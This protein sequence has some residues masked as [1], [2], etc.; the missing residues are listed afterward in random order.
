MDF[1]VLCLG[2]LCVFFASY[3]YTPIPSNIE[4]QWKVR[5]LDAAAKIST[6]VA[7]CFE[8][9]GIM[10][11]DEFISMILKLDYTEPFSDENITVTDMTF[12][13]IPVRLYLPKRKSEIPRRAVIYIHGGAYCLGSFKQRA[14]DFLNRW[15]A[16][17]LDAVV[18]G[19]DYRLAPQHLFPTQFEDCITLVKFFLQDEILAKYGVDPTRICVSGDSSGGMLAAAVTQEVQ[20]NLEIKHKI[21][22]QALL[23]P[24]LQIIDSCLPSY[25]ENKHGLVLTRDIGIKLVS[26][27]LT[28]DESLPEAMRRNQYMPMES[29]PLF[30]F[31]N[32]S[33]LLPKK[34]RKDYVYVEPILGRYNYSLP[35]LT[36]IR[37]SPLLA[38]DSLLQNLPSTYIL[39]CQYDIVR[40]DGIIYVSRLRNVGI[41]VTHEHI[42][43][44]I[45]AA[46]S[47]MTSP[48]YLKLG[49]RIRDLYISWLDKNV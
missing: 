4:E 22:L 7:M 34:Y 18:L 14:T 8:N 40:D 46:L 6:F 48:L 43:D 45:H 17:K 15:T 47:F 10:R 20:N 32:W 11:F 35:A 26:L 13:N 30:K 23:Y 16:N 24:N 33:T 25:Q 19:V 49:L 28:K 27:Y 44:G 1:K 12:A 9:I 21:K 31:V 37:M 3:I 38:S 42:E 36:D 2:L 29:R 41:K 39:T 5:I